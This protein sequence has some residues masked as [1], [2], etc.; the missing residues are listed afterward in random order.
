MR[1]P[2]KLRSS[3]S[4]SLLEVVV[5]VGIVATAFVFIF[6]G[7]GTVLSS[8]RLS[9]EVESACLLAEEAVWQTCQRLTAEPGLSELSGQQ[10]DAP[11]Q[12]H[13][14]ALITQTADTELGLRQVQLEVKWK[15]T[16]TRTG[17]LDVRTYYLP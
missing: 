15:E 1:L 10:P 17:Q 5:T 11:Q 9:R 8:S 6:R 2:V 16:A 14:Q 7:F 13:W 4:F 3:N 12:F